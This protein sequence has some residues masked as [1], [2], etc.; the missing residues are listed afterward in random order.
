M[1]S[2][3]L[4]VLCHFKTVALK[5]YSKIREI[6]LRGLNVYL[7]NIATEPSSI[8]GAARRILI[9]YIIDIIL[10]MGFAKIRVPDLQLK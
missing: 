2:K 3:L 4:A 10:I 1:I 7:P 8:T 9:M 5:Y 6:A